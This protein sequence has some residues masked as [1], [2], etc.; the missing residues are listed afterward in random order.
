MRMR[1]LHGGHYVVHRTALERAHRQGLGVVEM[2]ELRAA[3][4]P[5]QVTYR[6]LRI[7]LLDGRGQIAS[8]PRSMA[9]AAQA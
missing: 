4:W 9:R 2:A 7:A 1:R 3:G 8:A 6:T 5:H